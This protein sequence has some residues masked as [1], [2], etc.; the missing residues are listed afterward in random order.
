MSRKI[1]APVI[2]LMIL[3]ITSGCIEGKH[4]SIEGKN[5]SI[6]GE[7]SPSQEPKQIT[8][9]NESWVTNTRNRMDDSQGIDGGYSD[10]PPQEPTLYSTYYFLESLKLLDKEPKY[11]QA[12][13]DWLLSQEQE[14]TRQDNNSNI[15]NIY[16]LTLSL[17]ILKVKPAN[18]SNLIS[19]VM[20]LQMSDGSFAQKKGDKGALL[21]TFRAITILHTLGVDLNQVPLTKTW[22]IEKWMEPDENENLMYST[23]EVSLL[24]SALK[25]YQVNVSSLQNQSPRMEKIKE[26]RNIIEN[27]LKLLPDTQM[28]LLALSSFTD[29]L[30]INDSVSSDIRSNIETYL[31]KRQLE[32]GGFNT[33]SDKYGEP[34]GTYL[35]LKIAS[36]LGFDLNDNVSIFIYN[37]EPLNGSGGFRPAYRLISSSENTYLAVKS[38]K[39]LGSEP[40]DKEKLLKYVDN[41]WQEESKKAKTAYY[42]LVVCNLLNQ[43]YLTDTQFREWVKTSFDEFA[44]QSSDSMDLEEVLYVTKVANLLGIELNNK[45]K[46]IAKLQSSQQEDGGFGFGASDLFMTFYVVNTLE[47]LGSYPVDK[48]GCISWI[49]EGQITDGGFNLRR[50]PIHTNSSD[51]YSTY[52][53]VVSLNA[54]DAKPENS[55]KLLE[56]LKDCQDEHGG[57][58]LAPKYANLNTSKSS[59]EARLE[60]TSWGLMIWSTLSD[61]Q[62]SKNL[63]N[64][65]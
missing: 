43:P 51:I 11:K 40:S 26:Q 44:N 2:I 32:D 15:D 55:D 30:L 42:L 61:E 22:L 23:S 48:K 3:I 6:G 49:Q 38:L 16:F 37:Y 36:N 46:L 60:Y 65:S 13:I 39:I 57:F 52:I 63:Q 28:D 19:K 24:I 14:M 54:L 27:Q 56:W 64:N 53:S 9:L 18:R 35:A 62:T 17:D 45:D 58:K 1:Y 4:L 50:G 33:L 10:F 29:F 25:L 5:S 20:E 34:Q 21:D 8:N 7:Y 31:Q 47:E 12:T 59:F 41:N